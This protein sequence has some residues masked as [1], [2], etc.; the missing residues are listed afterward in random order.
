MNEMD[1]ASI[2]VIYMEIRF[3]MSFF[4]CE[5][6]SLCRDVNYLG[7]ISIFGSVAINSPSF[8]KIHPS[9]DGS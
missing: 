2:F 9:L 6:Q 1:F 4:I 5:K 7:L 3:N 8:G